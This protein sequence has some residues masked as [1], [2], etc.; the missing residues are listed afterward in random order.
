MKWWV[1]KLPGV[2]EWDVK[3]L[4]YGQFALFVVVMSCKITASTVLVIIEPSLLGAEAFRKEP[5][6]TTFSST[7]QY[8]NLCAFLFKDILLFICC[9]FINN[10]AN[11]KQHY[12]SC[13]NKAC[14][15]SIRHTTTFL[16][17]R[18]LEST[19][20]LLLGAILNSKIT[21]K[22]HKDGKNMARNRPRKGHL[23]RARKW[24]QEGRA[25]S[26][27]TSAGNM[28][29]R[30]LT[31]FRCRAYAHEGPRKCHEYWFGDC[32]TNLANR[33]LCIYRSCELWRLSVLMIGNS[34][35]IY[36]C[37]VLYG[38][39]DLILFCF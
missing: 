20:A 9:W 21:N 35:E 31:L 1:Q 18:T 26:R 16:L 17:L 10:M 11:D 8:I 13:L 38:N 30:W 39:G 5:L 33:Q 7:N 23:F 25:S 15:F 24:E 34:L 19:A 12:N 36:C 2:G 4:K 37:K 3:K 22:K 32:T 6:V 29:V 27:S 14:I 28:C